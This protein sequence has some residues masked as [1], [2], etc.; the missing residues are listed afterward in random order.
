MSTAAQAQVVNVLNP[1]VLV[2]QDDIASNLQGSTIRDEHFIGY[3][4]QAGCTP[5]LLAFPEP[6]MGTDRGRQVVR[7]LCTFRLWPLSGIVHVCD[8]CISE[9]HTGFFGFLPNFECGGRR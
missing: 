3:F 2:S 8:K 5:V 4:Q 1:S 6:L 7:L 9:F